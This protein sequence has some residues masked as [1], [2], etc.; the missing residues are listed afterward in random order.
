MMEAVTEARPRKQRPH[1]LHGA[2]EAIGEDP[3]D[4][5]RRLLLRCRALKLLIRLGKGRRAGLPSVAQVPDHATTDNRGKVDFV[6]KTAT[7]LLIGQE[8]VWQRQATR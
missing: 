7:V 8:I 4:P 1:A 5:V 2:V 6:C 3:F